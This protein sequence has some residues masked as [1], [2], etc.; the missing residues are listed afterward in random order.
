M[1]GVLDRV[2]PY[3]A[4]RM[5]LLGFAPLYNR[6]LRSLSSKD[7]IKRPCRIVQTNH[8]ARSLKQIVH[9]AATVQ[10]NHMNSYIQTI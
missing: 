5:G 3:D 6:P 2:A 4:M 9:T 10:P 8:A 7:R 1:H